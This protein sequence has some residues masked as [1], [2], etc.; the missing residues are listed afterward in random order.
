MTQNQLTYWANVE[1]ARANKATEQ[2]THRSNLVKEQEAQRAN[3]AAEKIDRTKTWV[4]A[5]TSLAS[6]IQ[7][8]IASS[9]SQ[10][11]KLLDALIPG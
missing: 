2:E 9:Q 4:N 3:L 11:T 5:A 1:R 6:T 10:A 7:K 8:H